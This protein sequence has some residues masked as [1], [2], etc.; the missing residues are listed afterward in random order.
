M[1]LRPYW[2]A[3][4]AV[5]QGED[6]D[7]TPREIA[8]KHTR[9]RQPAQALLLLDIEAAIAAERERCAKIAATEADYHKTGRSDW[10]RAAFAMGNKIALRIR[11]DP[12][13]G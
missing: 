5:R 4:A 2:D 1:T 6:Q 13:H 8:D 7:M 3:R 10:D 11:Q 12:P 9:G